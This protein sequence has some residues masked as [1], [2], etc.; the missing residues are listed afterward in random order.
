MITVCGNDQ[1]AEIIKHELKTAGAHFYDII[2]D[3][4]RKT[5]TKTRVIAS[6]HQLLRL[7]R[8]NRN[9]IDDTACD[10]IMITL[11]KIIS[12]VQVLILSDYCKGVLSKGLVK[13]I[14]ELCKKHQVKTIVDSKDKD[15]TKYIGT[16][17]FKPNK[18]EASIAAGINIVDDKTLEQACKV[19][20][21]TTNCEAVV[22]TLSEEGMAIYNRQKLDK[23]PTKALEVFDVTGAGDTVIASIAFGIANNMSIH[24]ACEFANHAAAVV[25]A[26]VGSATASIDE[27]NSQV[28]R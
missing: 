4:Q 27:I 25:V 7:D 12:D 9:D 10:Q 23:I 28:K 1:G 11:E 2:G 26:K 13:R 22:V 16:D 8:E 24:D 14:T 5:T 15:L 17:I 21:D 20:T 6:K 3:D 18:K 19:I